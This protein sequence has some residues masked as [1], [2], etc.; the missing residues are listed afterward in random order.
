MRGGS[1]AAMPLGILYKSRKVL[2][3]HLL[4]RCFVISEHVY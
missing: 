2:L 1:I 3:G 4:C